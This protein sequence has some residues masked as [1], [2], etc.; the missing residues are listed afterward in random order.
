VHV[1]T[2]HVVRC[3]PGLVLA[4]AVLE[5]PGRYH[6]GFLLAVLHAHSWPGNL[7][8]LRN[9]IERLMILSRNDGQPITADQLPGE[10]SD[11]LPTTPGSGDEHIMSMPLR[12]ARE[13][14]ERD[15][16]MAQ[17]TRFGGNISKT[18]NFIGMERSALHRKLK[19][20]GI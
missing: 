16:L 10:V 4:A 20:L 2:E 12:E 6:H 7:R 14:F 5:A 19:S 3:S 9:N 8:Q 1:A 11:M 18:A 13:I 15:Y 17:V